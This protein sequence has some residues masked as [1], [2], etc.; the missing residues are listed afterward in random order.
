M[1]RHL[2]P[3]QFLK[4]CSSYACVSMSL[5]IWM[6]FGG[7]LLIRCR[8]LVSWHPLIDTGVNWV[9]AQWIF[10]W[11]Q[12]F[13]APLSGDFYQF[14]P[15]PTLSNP[16][17]SAFQWILLTP[18]WLVSSL[19]CLLSFWSRICNEECSFL[20]SIPLSCTLFLCRGIVRA[21]GGGWPCASHC[22]EV[23]WLIELAKCKGIFKQGRA[24]QHAVGVWGRKRDDQ[25]PGFS[26][27]LLTV[28]CQKRSSLSPEEDCLNW[29]VGLELCKVLGLIKDK[30]ISCS[31]SS[32][33]LSTIIDGAPYEFDGAG[34]RRLECAR[35]ADETNI[36][37]A[38]FF[39]L[40]HWHLACLVSCW[41]AAF[42]A[43]QDKSASSCLQI[44]SLTVIRLS[45]NLSSFGLIKITVYANLTPLLFFFTSFLVDQ[46]IH[47]YSEI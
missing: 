34:K 10:R 36:L 2:K 22:I 7:L 9:S 45:Q 42:A 3:V 20:S 27:S 39:I 21:S 35:K 24:V 13:G 31:R 15:K 5:I 47:T 43:F 37:L 12:S 30:N 19:F 17:L 23:L 46:K 18:P 14:I 44:S 11:M 1:F 25:L 38:I 4:K 33:F 29:L 32:A 40:Q 26:R 41:N 6:C 28:I 8:K 16:N